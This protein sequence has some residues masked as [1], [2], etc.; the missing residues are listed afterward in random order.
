MKQKLLVLLVLA[1]LCSLCF[2]QSS[3]FRY[4]YITEK[5]V[6]IADINEELPKEKL[7]SGYPMILPLNTKDERFRAESGIRNVESFF[8]SGTPFI[9]ADYTKNPENPD[10]RY[11]DTWNDVLSYVRGKK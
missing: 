11:I 3:K 10:M 7:E 5:T 1:C 4:V 2:G 6:I 9:Y 8:Y